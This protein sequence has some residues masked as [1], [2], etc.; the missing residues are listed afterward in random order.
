MAYGAVRHPDTRSRQQL[1]SLLTVAT[2]TG[3]MAVGHALLL[4]PDGSPLRVIAALLFI[5]LP[6]LVWAELLIAHAEPILRWTTGSGLGFAIAILTGLLLHTLPGPILLWQW[7]AAVDLLVAV[8]LVGLLV[9]ANRAQG[10]TATEG[11]PR[12]ILLLLLLIVLLGGIFRFAELNYSEFQGDEIEA[13]APGA[14][15]IEGYDD[16]L[17]LQRRKAP[18]EVLLP[19]LMWRTTGVLTEGTARLPFAVA[20]LLIIPCSFV[21]GRRLLKGEAGLVT[22]L[23][24]A[25][26]VALCGLLVAFARVVQYQSL[27][28]LMTALSL[29]CA[30]EWRAAGA[31][32]WAVLAGVFLGSGLLA[33]YDAIAVAPALAFVGL[34]AVLQRDGTL[35]PSPWVTF[36]RSL[37]MAGACLLVAGPF[38]LAYLTDPAFGATDSY[39][40]GRVGNQILHDNLGGFLRI[41]SFYNSFYFVVVTGL[42]AWVAI[43]WPLLRWRRTSRL[44]GHVSWL[45]LGLAVLSLVLW[46]GV[47]HFFSF[48]LAAAVM[49]VLLAAALARPSSTEQRSLLLW[50]GCAFLAFVFVVAQ[51]GTHIYV[52]MLP[53]ALLAGEGAAMLWEGLPGRHTRTGAVA[54]AAAAAAAVLVFSGYLFAAYLRQDVKYWQDW[55]QSRLPFYW[56]P[57]EYAELDGFGIFGMVHRSGWKAAGAWLQAQPPAAYD[58]NEKPEVTVWYTRNA[59]R[60]SRDEQS[61]CAKKPPTLFIADDLVGAAGHYAVAPDDLT[62]Y[63]HT[64]TITQ[65]NGKGIAIYTLRSRTA[66]CDGHA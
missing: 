34:A 32:R 28:V 63:Q 3:I 1:A 10:E 16:A 59:P 54:V 23:T 26:I 15:A 5:L 52:T 21:M 41:T 40:A 29:L 13:V 53:L 64:G 36:G 55:P 9:T 44:T 61:Y 8:P 31:V 50:G 57:E 19:M 56:M 14:R 48:R 12:S 51:P 24:A 37:A 7:V 6:G 47:W 25:L 43:I 42:L 46:L 33:H 45:G 30:W 35:V 62:G 2:V 18:A 11:S 66:E 58:S 65:A 39:L 20:G 38:Y 17:T 49:V 60:P 27:V 4:A 22:G